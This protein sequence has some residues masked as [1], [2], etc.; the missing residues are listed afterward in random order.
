MVLSPIAHN[1]FS[2]KR[3]IYLFR[4]PFTKLNGYQL[5]IPFHNFDHRTRQKG[6]QSRHFFNISCVDHGTL[7]NNSLLPLF[8]SQQRMKQ[9]GEENCNWN[10]MV[11]SLFSIS[12][13]CQNGHFF[14]FPS[15]GL[16]SILSSCQLSRSWSFFTIQKVTLFVA[17]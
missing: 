1:N 14:N 11:L 16:G 15:T 2:C 13:R 17:F 7:L 6:R 5:V 9:G 8:S 4:K 12:N 10:H 3:Y